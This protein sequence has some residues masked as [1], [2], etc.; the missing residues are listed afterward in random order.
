[1]NRARVWVSLGLWPVLAAL[2]STACG[3]ATRPPGGQAGS[4]TNF[5]RGCD[6]TCESGLECICGVCT[7][8]CSSNGECA[9]LAK[10]AACISESE[11]SLTC[12]D[13][14]SAACDVECAADGDCGVLGG[15]F[16]CRDGSCREQDPIPSPVACTPTLPE[17]DSELMLTVGQ[18]T[19]SYRVHVPAGAS[20]GAAPLVLDFHTLA[21]SPATQRANSGYLELSDRTNLVVAWP[22]GIGASWNI[23]ACCSTQLGDVDDVGFAR[24][25]VDELASSA[26]IDRKRVYAAGVAIGGGLA[27]QLACA[28]TDIIA[29]VAPSAF[30]LLEESEQ[31]CN[32]SRPI[33]VMS[34]R[35]T[36]DAVVPYAGGA[37]QAPND[38][39]VTIHLLG[40]EATFQRWAALNGCSGEPS[41]KDAKGCATYSQCA[42]GVEVTLCTTDGGGTGYGSAELA[43]AMLQRFSLP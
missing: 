42:G 27:Y 9:A 15:D 35:G 39:A 16:R 21:G 37:V 18:S 33:S 25:L 43:W 6:A 8:R 26:C 12:A 3:D 36:A 13:A 28:A 24:A 17:G 14:P 7:R 22:Q 23:G 31:P 5:L 1:M 32:P 34:F 41:A 38:P 40:A 4:E 20:S 11:G 29:A 2:L 19:R 10:G 30:D